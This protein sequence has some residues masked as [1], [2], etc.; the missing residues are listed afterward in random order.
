VQTI[1][2]G[3]GGR[4]SPLDCR[5]AKTLLGFQPRYVWQDVVPYR[6]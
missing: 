4:M 2:E 5:K 3:Y 1:R 6:A